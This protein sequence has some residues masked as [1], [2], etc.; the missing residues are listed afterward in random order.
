[1]LRRESTA[2]FYQARAACVDKLLTLACTGSPVYNPARLYHPRL[3]GRMRKIFMAALVLLALGFTF[4]ASSA[5]A[6][7]GCSSCKSKC[8]TC[9]PC[10]SKCNSCCKSAC[11]TCKSKCDSCKPKCNSCE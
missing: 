8:N 3:E 5:Y 7:C 9:S 6:S 10:K 1:M 11:D 2:R 4:G